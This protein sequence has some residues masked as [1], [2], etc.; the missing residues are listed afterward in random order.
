MSHVSGR[1]SNLDYQRIKDEADKPIGERDKIIKTNRGTVRVPRKYHLSEERIQELQTKS[2]T[3]NPYR[4]GGFYYAFITSLTELGP[5]KRHSFIDVKKQL[6]KVMSGWGDKKTNKDGWIA[7]RDKKP[8]NSLCAC[9]VN[10]RIEQN[11]KILQRLT[12]FHPYGEK[13]RQLGMCVDIYKGSNGL[14]DFQLR[15]GIDNYED[16]VPVNEFRKNKK[17]D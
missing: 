17:N 8:K 9:D 14:P 6:K 16:V 10:G 1:R 13:L 2:E 11:A 12:G 4:R 5:D 15:T 7:F 3:P